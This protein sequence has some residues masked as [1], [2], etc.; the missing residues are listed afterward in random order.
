MVPAVLEKV[1]SVVHR[2]KTDPVLLTLTTDKTAGSKES[3]ASTALILLPPG[4]ALIVALN[5]WPELYVPVLGDRVK[6]AA[7]ACQAN[8][9]NRP[10]AIRATMSE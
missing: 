7:R 2:E 5:V 3:T 8:S 4:T 6:S 10:D 9:R 1:G